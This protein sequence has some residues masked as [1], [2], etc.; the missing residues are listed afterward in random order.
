MEGDYRTPQQDSKQQAVCLTGQVAGQDSV[1]DRTG[2]WSG[3]S[4]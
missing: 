4:V 3:Q 1:S 2:G